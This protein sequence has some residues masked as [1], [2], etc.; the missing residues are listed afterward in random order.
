MSDLDRI[1]ALLQ[2]VGDAKDELVRIVVRSRE[3][4]VHVHTDAELRG[5]ALASLH[6]MQDAADRAATCIG[7]MRTSSF[8]Q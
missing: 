2:Q 1:R 5:M 7:K 3:A 6:V 4:G 8:E